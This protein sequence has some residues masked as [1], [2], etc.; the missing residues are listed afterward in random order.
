M[1]SPIQIQYGSFVMLVLHKVTMVVLLGWTMQ[2]DHAYP[3][4]ILV[5]AEAAKIVVCLAVL[6]LQ[7][8]VQVR[9]I[10]PPSAVPSKVRL[11]VFLSQQLCVRE[12]LQMT[13]PATIYAAQNNLWLFSLTYIDPTTFQMINQSK[14]LFTALISVHV[15]GMRIRLRQWIALIMLLMGICLV[16]MHELEAV[17]MSATMAQDKN[18]GKPSHISSKSMWLL[19]LGAAI[20]AST[21]SAFASVYLEKVL[22]Q[23]NEYSI[24]ARNVH[25]GI[26]S[27]ALAC[28][29]MAYQEG[30]AV[31]RDGLFFG[32][33]S[34]TWL[35]VALQVR[36][37]FCS[38]PSKR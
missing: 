34:T 37:A 36:F 35:T 4:T 17:A 31:L 30:E 18:D 27:L 11:H 28:L 10:Q 3:T 29:W 13:L 14:I 8:F 22:K 16:Q 7:H 5:L 23:N 20:G 38:S 26:I 19:A 1:C 12:A 9:C 32:Y 33:A 21:T 24:W 6:A 25:L 2:R 15:L